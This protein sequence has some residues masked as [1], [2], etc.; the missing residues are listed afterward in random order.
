MGEYLRVFRHVGFFRWLGENVATVGWEYD[1]QSKVVSVAESRVP[2]PRLTAFN[3]EEDNHDCARHTNRSARCTDRSARCTDRSK[4]GE[5]L[6][7]PI[8]GRGKVET[9]L[10]SSLL[11]RFPNGGLKSLM[12]N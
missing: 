6:S 7:H 12:L 11:V 5:S 3:I 8:F 10:R 9:V 4:V 1:H 2:C